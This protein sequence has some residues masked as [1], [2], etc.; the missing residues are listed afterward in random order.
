MDRDDVGPAGPDQK[1]QPMMGR[2]DRGQDQDDVVVGRRAPAMRHITD[3]KIAN[4][5]AAFERQVAKSQHL[6][7]RIDPARLQRRMLPTRLAQ[8]HPHSPGGFEKPIGLGL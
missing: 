1:V 5:V 8:S 4:D 6:M 3:V 7:R 2:A